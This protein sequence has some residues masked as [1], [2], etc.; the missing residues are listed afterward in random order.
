MRTI[1]SVL[2][3]VLSFCIIAAEVRAEGSN[4]CKQCGDQRQACTK[5]YSAKVCKT[6][7]DICMKHCRA[8]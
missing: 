2:F 8:K 7:Y 4:S 3:V 6:E 1:I 5:N